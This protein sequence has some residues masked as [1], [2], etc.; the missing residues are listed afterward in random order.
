M[1]LNIHRAIRLIRV[2]EKGGREKGMEVGEE[3][4][5]IPIAALSTPE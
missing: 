2:G 4:D 3:G 1:V 5:D